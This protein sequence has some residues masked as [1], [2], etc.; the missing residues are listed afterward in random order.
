M[1]R[2]HDNL[3]EGIASFQALSQ[4]ARRAIRGK[5]AKPGACAFFANLERELLSLE[6]QL[7]DGSYRPG[8]YVAFEVNDPKKRIVSA[9][10]F[11]DRVVH[12][13]LCAVVEPI[14]EACFI[15]QTFANRKGKGTHRAINVY[16]GYRDRHAHVLRC[17]IYRYFPAIDHAL[18]KAALRRRIACARTLDLLDMIIDR[19]NAQ[20][21]VNLYFHGDN[22][23]APF[24]RRRGLP[25]GN[26]TSQFFANLYLDGFDHWVTEVLKAP[27]VRYVDDFAL[28]HDDAEVLAEWHDRIETYL[29]GRRLRAHPVKTY[30]APSARS[31]QFLGYEL[32]ADGGR[33]LPEENVRRFRNRLRGLRDQ[34][35]AGTVGPGDVEPR[36]RAWIA[37]AENADTWRLR[38]AI[39]RGGRFDPR[40]TRSLNGPLSPCG[41][42]R[43]LEQHSTEPPLRQPQQEHHRQPEQQPRFP[44]REHAVSQNRRDHGFAGRAP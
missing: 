27:Y 8:R 12:H 31:V 29:A 35:R 1:P 40:R 28:F 19:S 13:A 39:F 32:H 36:V 20:E 41:P 15:D 4:A 10:P 2:R 37:H 7:Q 23:F 38:H 11:R 42:R 17:D 24:E 22:L 43:F 21:P 30:I 18:L 34:W 25:I 44:C 14:F 3:F 5:R 16:E 6:R 26:L 9:A 33:S